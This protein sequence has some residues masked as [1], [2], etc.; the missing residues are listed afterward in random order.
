MVNEVAHI[1][2]RANE[3]TLSI[4]NVHLFFQIWHNYPVRHI[5]KRWIFKL[6]FALKFGW[7]HFHSFI[8]RYSDEETDPFT[9][10]QKVHKN[11]HKLSA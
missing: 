2:G 11:E 1:I 5:L 10:F 3:N 4:F 9:Y 8:T 7:I 6:Q